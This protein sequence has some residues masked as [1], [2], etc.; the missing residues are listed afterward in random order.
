MPL[1]PIPPTSLQELQRFI[2]NNLNQYDYT[3]AKLPDVLAHI[4]RTPLATILV[5]LKDLEARGYI[6]VS[7]NEDTHEMAFMDV[8]RRDHK[9]LPNDSYIVA[10][11]SDKTQAA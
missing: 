6:A 3:S 5:M 1:E 10:E 4:S 8:K 2:C 9:T 7:W 11:F